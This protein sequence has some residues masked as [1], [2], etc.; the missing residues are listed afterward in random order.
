MIPRSLRALF[1]PAA[2]VGLAR[3][4]SCP[5]VATGHHADDQMETVLMRLLRGAGPRGLGGMARRRALARAGPGSGAAK[6]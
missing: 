6:R 1:L 2:L 5:F 4:H 3:A